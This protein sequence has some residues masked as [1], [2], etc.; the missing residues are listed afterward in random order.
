M[1]YT[2]A[3]L[4]LIC[5]FNIKTLL[6]TSLHFTLLRFSLVSFSPEE[7]FDQFDMSISY[8]SLTLKVKVKSYIMTDGQ[9]ASLSVLGLTVSRPVYLVSGT[10]LG[11]ATNSSPSLF[12]YF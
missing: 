5:L 7:T 10:H 6:F 4:V 8:H 2:T 11:P 1:N 9:S 3:K 12:N